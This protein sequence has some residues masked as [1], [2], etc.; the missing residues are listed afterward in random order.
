MC[1]LLFDAWTIVNI[2]EL[3]VIPKQSSSSKLEAVW[4]REGQALKFV[5]FTS[6]RD[7]MVSEINAIRYMGISSCT[8]KV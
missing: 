2:S 6:C 5:V 8:L 7:A 4:T 1:T 3:D